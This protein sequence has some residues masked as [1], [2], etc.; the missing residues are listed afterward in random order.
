[1][2]IH[3]HLPFLNSK[4]ASV[5]NIFHFI[6]KTTY[7]TTYIYILS[8]LFEQKLIYIAGIDYTNSLLEIQVK[9]TPYIPLPIKQL[10]LQW[11]LYFFI[12]VENCSPRRGAYIPQHRLYIL[13]RGIHRRHRRLYRQRGGKQ[14]TSDTL[15]GLAAFKSAHLIPVG[16]IHFEKTNK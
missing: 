12:A 5:K 8:E 7:F 4:R 11:F 14:P 16:C 2:L 9:K 6:V 15:N 13:R 3:I 10:H 1:M